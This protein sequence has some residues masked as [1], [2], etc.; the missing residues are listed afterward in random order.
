MKLNKYEYFLPLKI[1]MCIYIL[2]I[3]VF[4]DLAV[5][6]WVLS[7][8]F[9]SYTTAVFFFLL[10]LYLRMCIHLFIFYFTETLRYGPD[11]SVN[12]SS[13]SQCPQH[14]SRFIWGSSKA[15]AAILK[16]RDLSQF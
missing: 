14:F 3:S 2:V 7:K 9:S 16:A 11:G 4:R 15:K 13:G 1:Y 12:Q 6:G 5:R 10:S 8:F